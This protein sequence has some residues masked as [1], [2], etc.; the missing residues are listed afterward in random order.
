MFEVGEEVII[1]E[2]SPTLFAEDGMWNEKF[3]GKKAIIN[4]VSGNHVRLVVRLNEDEAETILISKERV[5]KIEF[6][7][8]KISN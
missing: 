5:E 3:A 7:N 6:S 2:I 1:R 8:G 4:Y